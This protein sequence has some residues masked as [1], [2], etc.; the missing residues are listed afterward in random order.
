MRNQARAHQTQKQL[1]L[2]VP[3]ALSPKNQAK[4]FKFIDLFAG[5]GG[6]RLAFERV[7]G[8]CVL[9]SEIDEK[10]SITYETNF[11][12]TPL[13]DIKKIKTS[14]IPDH[15]LLLAGFPCQP[16]SYAGEKKGLEDDRGTLF[17]QILRVLK[18][19][20]PS[21]FLL[22]NVKGLTS[23]NEGQILKDMI[24]SLEDLGYHVSY[25]VMN[26]KEYGNTPQTRERIY[27]VGF[28]TE[29]SFQFPKPIKLRKKIED[30]LEKKKQAPSFYYDRFLI[31]KEL[32][33]EIK[34]PNTIYQWRRKY[35]RE[36]KSETCPT[37]TANMGTGGHNVPLIKDRYGI[38]KLTPRECA[39]FQGFPD[40]FKLPD[41][42][43]SHLYKQ[44][45]N[46]VSVPVVERIA[47]EMK[48][49]LEIGRKT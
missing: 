13:G 21:S 43:P 8:E 24:R 46:S 1:E 39:R 41:I 22:E 3:K 11:K 19:K 23:L 16:F 42:A 27:I 17:F 36:N 31:H 4:T 48:K 20:K 32:K 9:S 12:S 14:Q 38:R 40:S 28:L 18:A 7:G 30:I 33:K 26:T 10:A 49:C 25:K 6:L 34:K 37:L 2:F 44:I 45:G 15:D 5:I 29:T 35:V 47:K